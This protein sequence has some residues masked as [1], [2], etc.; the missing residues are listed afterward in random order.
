M[1][2]YLSIM[3]MMAFSMSAVFISCSDDNSGK[4][5][6][7]DG[8]GDTSYSELTPEQQK[9]KINDEVRGVV[10]KLQDLNN[11]SALELLSSFDLLLGIAAPEMD[12]ESS[13]D[14]LIFSDF[15]GVYTWNAANEEWTKT[16]SSNKLVFN[17]PATR[18]GNTN[19]GSIE[20]IYEKSG[21]SYED[22]ELPKK[23]GVV[24]K[25]GTIVVGEISMSA[26]NIANINNDKAPS[27]TEFVYKLDNY[28]LSFTANKGNNNTSAFSLKK[29]NETIFSA[30]AN[31]TANV[32]DL[33]NKGPEDVIKN[34]NFEFLLT[35]D[36]ALKG[37][38]DFK[39]LNDAYDNIDAI[40]ENL[41]YTENNERLR[42]EAEAKA[43]NEFTKIYLV[44]RKDGNKK[45]ADMKRVVI[46]ETYWGY[47]YYEMEDVLVF[48]DESEIAMS[49]YF[50]SGF[51][52]LI[53]EW[54]NFI[55]DFDKYVN[56]DGWLSNVNFEK[57]DEIL[58]E[59]NLWVQLDNYY[60][61]TG[62]I[63]YVSIRSYAGLAS[64]KLF[65]DW[66][67]YRNL[68]IPAPNDY[69]MYEL[70]IPGLSDGSYMLEVIDQWGDG[71]MIQFFVG[72]W[73]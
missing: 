26:D 1:K 39:K 66:Q 47:T 24:L 42:A 54:E 37:A 45:I 3:L 70:T 59:K 17:L 56:E 34:G 63:V 10:G 4:G 46:A 32:D 40:Y 64:I 48:G 68:N 71:E 67:L 53:N 52:T 30:T 21:A 8:D 50:G 31:L 9:G 62:D 58:V 44:S 65:K 51:N 72:D 38:I 28:A 35:A 2:K 15:Y 55:K 69:G 13:E 20:V 27:K 57:D 41:P 60:Y 19:N 6:D 61:S 43:W 11:S 73:W 12:V 29:G 33:F 7:G 49:T 22:V 5:G 36:L 14:A 18:N 16:P 23:V 25:T